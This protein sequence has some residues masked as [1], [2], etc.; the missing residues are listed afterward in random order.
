MKQTRLY[1]VAPA[2]IAAGALE[3][4]VAELA[5]AGVDVVQLR[6]KEMEARDVLRLGEPILAACRDA[7]VPFIVNDRPD[8]ALALGA[9]GVHVGQ[10]DLPIEAVRRILPSQIVGLSTHAPAEVDDAPAI[11]GVDYFAVGP[12]FA[13]P[14]KL[15]RPAAGLE[16]ISH[17]AALGTERPWFA[18]GGID[19]TNLGSVMDAG[20]RRIVVVRAI[21]EAADPVEAAARLR[22]ELDE[23]PL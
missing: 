18:I 23:I 6:E 7:G 11:E 12:V 17:A 20:A 10:N 13:T 15:G 14:T 3:D 1:L 2:R 22:V 9:D 19:E 5:G 4:V 16:L 21:T 8:I